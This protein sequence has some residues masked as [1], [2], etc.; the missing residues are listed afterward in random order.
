MAD[1]RTA[2]VN[3][4]IDRIYILS[5]ARADRPSHKDHAEYM[6][7]K[8]QLGADEDEKRTRN[9]VELKR[10]TMRRL[11]SVGQKDDGAWQK[12]QAI[13]S[14]PSASAEDKKAAAARARKRMEDR[15]REKK[16][17]E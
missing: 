14:D 10:P 9:E 12:D 8:L 7:L 1:K 3:S 11:A 13:I 2:G 17:Q 16:S 5:Q 4:V 15:A 6:K